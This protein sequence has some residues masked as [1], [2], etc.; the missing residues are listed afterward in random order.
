MTS[1]L[2]YP[3]TAAVGIAETRLP[4]ALVDQLPAQVA[5][6]PW[7]TKDC[8]VTTWMHLLDTSALEVYPPEIRP[9]S[10]AMVAWALV[11]YGD[12]P[13]GPYSELAATLIAGDGE[14]Y[15]HIPFIVVDS[16][17]SIVGGRANWLLPKALARFDWSADKLA[18]S[19]ASE[20]PAAPVWSVRVGITLADDASELTV[21]NHLQ[22]VSTDG[23]VRRFDGEI[24]GTVRGA[25]IEVEAS[26]TG[27][28]G[29]LLKSGSYDGTMITDCDFRMGA[30]NS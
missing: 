11:E 6:A 13:V 25:R 12:T 10:I 22:Q 30:L 5:P 19:I 24:T 15:A 20:Q 18:V 4:D 2:P 26:A 1:V 9:A 28:L 17:P 29:L 8:R 14:E 23:D 7:H 27:T 3:V 21:P 16:L